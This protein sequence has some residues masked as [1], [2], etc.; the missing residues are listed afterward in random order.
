[1]PEMQ[2]EKEKRKKKK[3]RPYLNALEKGLEKSE[4]KIKKKRRSTKCM[5]ASKEERQTAL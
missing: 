3:S 1:M 2:K 5:V 4:E